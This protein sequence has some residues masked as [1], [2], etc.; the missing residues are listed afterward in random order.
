MGKVS[1][2]F[3]K[4]AL[5]YLLATSR[6]LTRWVPD[7]VHLSLEYKIR[8]G[9]YPDLVHPK[10]F[11]E[12]LQWLKMHDR[13]PLYVRLV[14][15]LNAKEW[16]ANRIGS[17]YVT[18][19]YAR[20]SCAEDIDISRLPERFVLK[21][22]H[23]C[24]GISICRNRASFDLESEKTK[25]AKHLKRNYYWGG[26]EWPYKDVTPCVFAEEY[27]EPDEP[28]SSPASKLYRFSGGKIITSSVID[29][30]TEAFAKAGLSAS[31]FD[32]EW[33]PIKINE[34]DHSIHSDVQAHL[35]G[36]MHLESRLAKSFPIMRVDYYESETRS[37]FSEIELSPD[38]GFEC[39]NPRDWNVDAGSWL[40][41]P[42]REGWLLVN[43]TSLMWV[44]EEESAGITQKGLVDYKFYCFDGDPKFL[45]VSQ[46]LENHETARISFL[47]PDWSF[48]P[49]SRN[50][51]AHFEDL[52]EKPASFNKMV[53]FARMLSN[54]I[55]FVRVD[56]YEVGGEPRFSEMTF[57]PCSGYM[58]FRP[59]EWDLRVGELLSLEGAYGPFGE[60]GVR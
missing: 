52:P 6:G 56:F 1:K 26:R 44:H 9:V 32:D 16:V 53:E 36:L 47:N 43:N 3:R 21:T 40:K 37:C 10:T 8:L 4:P 15:K 28:G 51:Y 17:E 60:Q 49:F 19:T 59:V 34:S 24:G 39:F 20:W 29:R 57:H 18:E 50:D 14:D 27:L 30:F 42:M 7:S 48:A 41:M 58:P 5:L 46:G 38:S 31:F 13:N 54:G 22:N 23:D 35:D 11:N 55:P 12:K 45:Y 2:Y 33:R 25:L